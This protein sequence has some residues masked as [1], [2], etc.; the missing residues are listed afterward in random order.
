MSK[1]ASV[2]DRDSFAR[3]VQTEKT[4]DYEGLPVLGT[5][6]TAL[7]ECIG[8]TI[9]DSKFTKLHLQAQKARQDAADAEKGTFKLRVGR[10]GTLCVYGIGQF[11][12]SQLFASQWLRVLDLADDIRAFIAAKPVEFWPA[13]KERKVRGQLI[14]AAVPVVVRLSTERG[15]NNVIHSGDA[16]VEYAKAHNIY[17]ESAQSDE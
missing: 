13:T 8:A 12:I 2:A 6:L 11:P 1:F 9:G 16:A 15:D 5:D 10:K 7:A 3:T 4:G 14:A 17:R